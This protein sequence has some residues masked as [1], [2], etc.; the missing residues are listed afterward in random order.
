MGSPQE[1]ESFGVSTGPYGNAYT[2]LTQ[3]TNEAGYSDLDVVLAKYDSTGAERWARTLGS[4]ADEMVLGS[5]VNRQ[6]DLFATGFTFGNLENFVASSHC[7]PTF[8]S[9]SEYNY[10]ASTNTLTVPEDLDND[11]KD[12]GSD[13]SFKVT[14]ASGASYSASSADSALATVS[15][16]DSSTGEFTLSLKK[17]QHGS[18]TITAS[19]SCGDQSFTLNVTSIDD[20]IGNRKNNQVYFTN[21]GD[22]FT[23]DAKS[24]CFTN[25]NDTPDGGVV[26]DNWSIKTAPV[27]G[28][29][30]ITPSGEWWYQ[31]SSTFNGREYFLVEVYD[32]D[33]FVNEREICVASVADSSDPILRCQGQIG[34]ATDNLTEQNKMDEDGGT[35]TSTIYFHD[36]NNQP[37]S[38]QIINLPDNG[39][40]GYYKTTD[41]TAWLTNQTDNQTD[42]NYRPD[43]NYFGT[44]TFVIQFADGI[45]NTNHV[46]VKVK[47]KSVNDKPIPADISA[48]I[49]EDNSS[50]YSVN[51]SA[52]DIEDAAITNF[53]KNSDPLYGTVSSFNSPTGTFTF[54]PFDNLSVGTYTTTLTYHV[55]DSNNAQ[56]V[57]PAT[58]TLTVIGANDQPVADNK[59]PGMI[60]E[61]SPSNINLSATDIDQDDSIIQ[62]NITSLPQHGMLTDNATGTPLNIG[63]STSS[64]VTFTPF[65]N[66]SAS[67]SQATSFTYVVSDNSSAANDTSDNATVSLT[68]NGSNDIPIAGTVVDNVTEDSPATVTLTASDVDTGDGL[69]YSQPITPQ[70]GTITNFN[71]ATGTF[72]FTPFDSLSHNLSYTEN[73]SYT[74]QDSQGQNS[75]S[76]SVTLNLTGVNDSPVANNVNIGNINWGQSGNFTLTG[77]DIDGDN[78]TFTIIGQPQYAQISSFDNSTGSLVL[79]PNNNLTNNTTNADNLTFTVTDSNNAVSNTATVSFSVLGPICSAN[80]EGDFLNSPRTVRNNADIFL[81]KYNQHGDHLWSRQIGSTADDVSFAVTTD[82]QGNTYVTGFTQGLLHGEANAG[83]LDVFLIK[84]SSQGRELWRRQFGSNGD[85]TGLAITTDEEAD[86]YLTGQTNGSLGGFT[87]KGGKDLFVVKYDTQGDQQWI[88]QS[89]TDQDDLGTEISVDALGRLNLLSLTATGGS[90]EQSQRFLNR[91]HPETGQQLW[92][93]PLENPSLEHQVLALDYTG[94]AFLAGKE[95]ADPDQ[96][97]SDQILEYRPDSLQ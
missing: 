57:T 28:T 6:G 84:F 8:P 3:S 78:F 51:L 65:D 4:P 77:S 16:V 39:T 46:E 1:I 20:T 95:V 15:A 85:E 89:G 80:L 70:Y 48:T 24:A 29:A 19:S 52:T 47:V 93:L 94:N 2:H 34:S 62:Y 35:E 25:D 87:N 13:Q 69:T 14:L 64:V 72:T 22:N 86:V 76:A 59:T 31:P 67:F 58:V 66:L 82:S 30:G 49:T 7:E 21:A 18:T 79:T 12:P 56:S 27:N 41:G 55:K 26:S 81:T 5:R 10:D 91:F 33:G 61:G 60:T 32:N 42:W 17:N 37:L 97:G 73:L 90:V 50:S 53:I 9:N 92:S 43:E 54:T 71:S 44:E 75:S 74:V 38:Y 63:S 96:F 40:A 36:K 68:V 45:G 83:G 11:T 23:C 88:Y